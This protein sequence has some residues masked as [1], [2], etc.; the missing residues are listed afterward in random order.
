MNSGV[1]L[2]DLIIWMW[3]VALLSTGLLVLTTVIFSVD[4]QQRV[5]SGGITAT[6]KTWLAHILHALSLVTILIPI[7][8]WW[9][10]YTGWSTQKGEPV[11]MVLI[12]VVGVLIWVFLPLLMKWS[13]NDES[14]PGFFVP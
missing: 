1:Y 10:Q 5:L 4:A 8:Y 3:G 9:V 6:R 2:P 12:G 11:V 7:I 14:P 13:R